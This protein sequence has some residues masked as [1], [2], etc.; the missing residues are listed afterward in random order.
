MTNSTVR[1]HIGRFLLGLFYLIV[2][3]QW[4]WVAAVGLPAV[5]SGDTFDSLLTFQ[6]P[7]EPQQ[8]SASARFSPILAIVAGI[9]SLIFLVITV[10]ILIRLPKTIARTG[11]AIV[12]RTTDVL[13]P[14]ITHHKPLATKKRRSISAKL[15][16]SIQLLL[17]L[18][19]L[20]VSLF[21]P[22]IET[23]TSQI[24][25]TLSAW[26]AAASGSILLLHWLLLPPSTLRTQSRAFR[27]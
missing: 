6:Q 20:L 8:T 25:I 4:L 15:T 16:I 19:P 14:V 5:V 23:V 11:D 9:I 10:Y 26:L 3:L 7:T 21:I 1:R 22:S 17:V 27:E 18:L 24:I 2:T 13:I 12:H